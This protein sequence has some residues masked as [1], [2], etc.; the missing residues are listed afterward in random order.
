MKSFLM[1]M[2]CIITMWSTISRSEEKADDVALLLAY[3]QVLMQKLNSWTEY[4][5]LGDQK[6]TAGDYNAALEDYKKAGNSSI[7]ALLLTGNISLAYCAVVSLKLT[8][9]EPALT[10]C[11]GNEN[12]AACEI[13]RTKTIG[14]CAGTKQLCE[15]TVNSWKRVIGTMKYISV[16]NVIPCTPYKQKISI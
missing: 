11:E 15:K 5:K 6:S 2:I 12:E 14:P 4:E 13:A 10:K 1:V 8:L 7:D 9:D 16:S 3:Q